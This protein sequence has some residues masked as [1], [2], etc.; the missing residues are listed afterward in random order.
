MYCP[1]CGLEIK[2]KFKFCPKCGFHLEPITILIES[3]LG[4]TTT[5]AYSVKEIRKTYVMAY[6]K[7]TKSQEDSLTADYK[8][9]LTIPQL[10]KKY[11]RKEGA[12]RSRLNRLGLN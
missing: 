9:G 12:I 4:Q 10:A 1:K 2:N 7:W 5:K 3:P 6:Q 11:G 8:Q